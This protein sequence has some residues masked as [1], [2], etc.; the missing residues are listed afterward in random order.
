[1]I[2]SRLFL[3]PRQNLGILTSEALLSDNIKINNQMA[4]GN[5][6]HLRT[7]DLEFQLTMAPRAAPVFTFTRDNNYHSKADFASK[8]DNPGADQWLSARWEPILHAAPTNYFANFS[9]TN[10]FETKTKSD[11]NYTTN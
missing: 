1:M 10:T 3:R 4:M 8:Y 2:H 5:D 11:A 9:K 7:I 6:R